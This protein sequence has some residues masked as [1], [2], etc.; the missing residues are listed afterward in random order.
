MSNSISIEVCVDSLASAIAAERGGAQRVELCSNLR[1]GG[2]TPSAGLIETVRAKAAIGLHVMIRPRGGDFCY[3]AEELET[4]RRDVAFAQRLGA[5]GVVFGVL[6]RDGTVDVKRTRE[7]VELARP[8][9]VTFHR[10]F[11][12]SADLFRALE[13]V[14]ETGA[15]RILTSGG[16]Q[17]ALETIPEISSLVKAAGRRISIMAC[18]GIRA[19]NAATIIEQT[20]AKEI[21]VGLS[22]SVPRGAV[23]KN[24]LVSL[25]T[26]SGNPDQ[27]FQVYEE[28]VRDLHR[29]TATVKV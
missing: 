19:G 22:R 3:S 18:G 25:G 14:C 23:Y 21:H 20:G 11:D 24:P 29:A 5:D 6:H 10:A 7:L 4:M 13:D 1:E 12:L 9:R 17:A 28:D 8:L 15:D 27:R 26:N 2:V 16:K